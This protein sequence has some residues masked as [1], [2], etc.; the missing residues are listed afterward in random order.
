MNQINNAPPEA[1]NS[2]FMNKSRNVLEAN[3]FMMLFIEGMSHELFPINT[4]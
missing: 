4:V 2:R 1:H 3:Q